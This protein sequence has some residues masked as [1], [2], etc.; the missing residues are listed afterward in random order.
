MV[1]EPGTTFSFQF[2]TN[3]ITGDLLTPPRGPRV[4]MYDGTAG[5]MLS[6]CDLKT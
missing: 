5:F 3:S 4:D 1:G 2:E 6:V